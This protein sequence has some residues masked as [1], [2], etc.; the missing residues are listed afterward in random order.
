MPNALI[1]KMQEIVDYNKAAGILSEASQAGERVRFFSKNGPK[2]AKISEL[3]FG[4]NQFIYDA[5]R[6]YA[7]GTLRLPFTLE[8]IT[9]IYEQFAKID[10]DL[11][12]DAN[13]SDEQKTKHQEW[14]AFWAKQQQD[15]PQLID[16]LATAQQEILAAYRFKVLNMTVFK[17]KLNST[18]QDEAH[19]QNYLQEVNKNACRGLSPAEALAD[20]DNK[21]DIQIEQSLS[22]LPKLTVQAPQTTGLK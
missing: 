13:G 18:Q 7:N 12:G 14:H 9:K 3:G 10:K 5:T 1:A 11:I 15:F 17:P 8:N 16:T 4:A 21:L 19:V 6:N 22:I 20:L 2:L